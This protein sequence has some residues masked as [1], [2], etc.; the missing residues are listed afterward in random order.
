MKRKTE[1]KRVRELDQLKELDQKVGENKM[2]FSNKITK[3]FHI[4]IV[5]T[6]N[7]EVVNQLKYK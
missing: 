7:K 1:Q 3:L 2:N 5:E 6:P 4:L